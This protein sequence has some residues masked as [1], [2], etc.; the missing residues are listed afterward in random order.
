VIS[1]TCIWDDWYRIKQI[2]QKV[3]HIMHLV[4]TVS[5]PTPFPQRQAVTIYPPDL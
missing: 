3:L 2:F 1:R 4:A 5:H